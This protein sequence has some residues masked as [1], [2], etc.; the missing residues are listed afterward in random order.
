M[1]DTNPFALGFLRRPVFAP[2][3]EGTGGATDTKDTGGD[4]GADATG[5]ANADDQ[6]AAPKEEQGTVLDGGTA[7]GQD[8]SDGGEEDGDKAGEAEGEKPEVPESYEFTDLP[9]GMELD[10]TLTEAVS[11][12]FKELGLTQDQ[13]SKLVQAYAGVMANQA[14]AMADQVTEMVK[15]WVDTAKAD[16]EIGHNNWQRSVDAANA[17]LRKFGT[18]ELVQEVMVNQG[19]GNHPEVIRL[20]ARIGLSVSDDTLITGEQT[21][22]A[23]APLEAVWYGETT[24]TSKKG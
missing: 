21:D 9:G 8:N 23:Q 10:A 5:I 16:K 3:D 17:V 7:K 24:P 20:L 18:P 13:A 22:T 11:P 14:Q 2:A 1:I 15:G 6:G 12:V 19:M 4:A